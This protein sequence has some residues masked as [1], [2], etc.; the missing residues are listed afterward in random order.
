MNIG[1]MVAKSMPYVKKFVP[2]A[3]GAITGVTGAISEQKAAKRLT[4]IEDRLKVVEE[5]AKKS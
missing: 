3:I 1:T 4:D 2:I 5:L